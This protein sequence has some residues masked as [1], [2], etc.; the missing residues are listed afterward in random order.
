MVSGWTGIML[1]SL[2]N[3]PR[4][5]QVCDL[6]G[7][8]SIFCDHRTDLQ[9]KLVNSVNIYSAVPRFFAYAML[10]TTSCGLLVRRLR[11]TLKPKLPRQFKIAECVTKEMCAT[12]EFQLNLEIAKLK[13]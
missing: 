7:G 10:R 5:G 3:I 4:R 11:S 2:R 12:K 13:R 9:H 1:T 6:H 8:E